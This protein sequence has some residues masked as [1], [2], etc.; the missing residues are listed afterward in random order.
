MNDEKIP[1]LAYQIHKNFD[2]SQILASQCSSLEKESG[3]LM[4][5]NSVMIQKNG[6][7]NAIYK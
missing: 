1:D 5:Y 2:Q 7:A 6:Q 3:R 4:S